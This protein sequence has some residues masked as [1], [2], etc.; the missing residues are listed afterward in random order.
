MFVATALKHSVPMGEGVVQDIY[1][2]P[3]RS[4]LVKNMNLYFPCFAMHEAMYCVMFTQGSHLTT[5]TGR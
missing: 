5:L 3:S 1:V 4:L 2:K